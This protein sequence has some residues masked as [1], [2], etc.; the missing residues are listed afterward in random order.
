MAGRKKPATVERKRL[1]MKDACSCGLKASRP[2]PVQGALAFR[3]LDRRRRG[4][5][6][7]RAYR[8]GANTFRYFHQARQ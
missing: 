3:H 6:A 1:S 7:E 2:S 4:M 5:A 8:L